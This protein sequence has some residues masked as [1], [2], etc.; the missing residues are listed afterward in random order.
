MKY[1]LHEDLTDSVLGKNI[2]FSSA[3]LS[4]KFDL[5]VQE[6]RNLENLR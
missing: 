5:Y 1:K 2:V 6:Q 3:G 4:K